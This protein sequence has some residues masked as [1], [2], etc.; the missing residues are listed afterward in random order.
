MLTLAM[1]LAPYLVSALGIVL[2]VYGLEWLQRSWA[3]QIA[4]E[5]AVRRASVKPW[6]EVVELPRDAQAPD[7]ISAGRGGNDTARSCTRTQEGPF[8]EPLGSDC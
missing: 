1:T 7:G 6:G 2:A 4:E 5:E 3:E 8:N